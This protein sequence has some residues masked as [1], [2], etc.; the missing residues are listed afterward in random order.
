MNPVQYDSQML[1]KGSRKRQRPSCCSIVVAP[2]RT[3][4]VLLWLLLRLSS[5]QSSNAFDSYTF[6]PNSLTKPFQ[7]RHGSPLFRIPSSHVSHTR[8]SHFDVDKTV[9]RQRVPPHSST[10]L[11]ASANNHEDWRSSS[12]HRKPHQRRQNDDDASKRQWL[13]HA[14]TD[15]IRENDLSLGK[16]HQVVRLIFA[17]SQFRKVFGPTPLRMESLLK[18]LI[19]GRAAHPNIVIDLPVYNAILNAWTCAALFQTVDDEFSRIACARAKELLRFLQQEGMTPNEYSFDI[20]LHT[21][22]KTEGALEARRLLAWMEYLYKTGRNDHAK[23]SSGDYIQ[24]LEAYARLRS[25]QSG[26]LADGVLTHMEYLHENDSSMESPAT[27]CYNIVLKA[28]S[29]ARK[30]GL[31]GREVAEHAD[32]ILEQMKQRNLV[33]CRPDRFTYSCKSN[34]HAGASSHLIFQQLAYPCGLHLA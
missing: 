33:T 15:M 20:V 12:R 30:Y 32:R 28:W 16:W 7:R 22:L 31:S 13:E 24:I 17:W 9:E 29:N 26:S 19:A 2:R 25:K 11:L 6:L 3:W 5:P 8:F 21:V 23:P 34:T 1:L 14:T 4:M 18:V 10:R 27:I